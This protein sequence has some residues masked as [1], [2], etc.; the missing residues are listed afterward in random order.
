MSGRERVKGC[1]C[2]WKHQLKESC[3]ALLWK[4]QQIFYGCAF[5]ELQKGYWT[6]VSPGITKCDSQRLKALKAHISYMVAVVFFFGPTACST[7]PC[8]VGLIVFILSHSRS[9]YLCFSFLV[10]R[11]KSVLEKYSDRRENFEFLL[12]P[13]QL[14]NMLA[15]FGHMWPVSGFC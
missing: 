3:S 8:L 11:M 1:V 9:P 14:T 7:N 4:T 12:W 13:P 10:F 5:W 15:D 6:I 2:V